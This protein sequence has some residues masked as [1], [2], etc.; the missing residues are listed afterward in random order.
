[1]VDKVTADPLMLPLEQDQIQVAHMGRG[2]SNFQLIPHNPQPVPQ[3]FILL[4]D[5]SGSMHQPTTETGPVMKVYN[6]L[7][8]KRVIEGFFP[9]KSQ[10]QRGVTLLKFTDK[11]YG[12]DGGAPRVITSRK[13]YKK[14]VQNYMLGGPR[15]WTYLYKAVQYTVTEML[16]LPQIQNWLEMN[17]AE[18]TVVA[19][20]DGFNNEQSSD[21][22]ATNAPRL[23]N[24]LEIISAA[25]NAPLGLRPTLY[26]VGLGKPINPSFEVPKGS[27]TPSA[28]KLCGRYKDSVINAGLERLGI[29]NPSMAWMAAVGGGTSFSRNSHKGLAKVFVAAAAE[30]YEW[31]EVYYAVDG[32]YHRRSFKTQIQ[33]RAFAKGSGTV[34]IFPSGW[35]DAPTG[36]RA[37]GDKWVQPAPY[38]NTFAFLLPFLSVLMLIS[39]WGPASF[40]A[41]R[42]VFRRSIASV[43]QPSAPAAAPA[44]AAPPPEGQPPPA[45]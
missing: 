29:D 13:E 24:T 32:F 33:L 43:G 16:V 21:S 14:T 9:K 3:L 15:G 42:A 25:R 8:D 18:P 4:I 39:F 1:L 7:M 12:F 2:V 34:E 41:R 40:N 31:Y 17:V 26:T 20:T 30:R 11:V 44:E 6:A 35:F 28:G 45:A 37:E 27:L 10:V 5:G 38:R 23:K 19:L 36:S 22:C